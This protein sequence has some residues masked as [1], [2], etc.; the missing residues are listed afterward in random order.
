MNTDTLSPAA[1]TLTPPPVALPRTITEALPLAPFATC[2]RVVYLSVCHERRELTFTGDD[3][4]RRAERAV[5]DIRDTLS[6]RSICAV[7]SWA[8]APTASCWHAD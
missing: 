4:L 1:D 3:V 5:A 8:S 2:I 6:G 7:V